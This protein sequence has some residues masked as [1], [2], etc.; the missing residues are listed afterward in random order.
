DIAR[1]GNSPALLIL[2]WLIT[3]F[4]TIT[5]ALAY[6]E[7]AAMMPK[8]GGQY[9]FLRE[10]LGPLWGFLYGWTLFLVIQTGTIAAVGVAFGTFLGYFFPAISAQNWIVH[11]PNTNIGLSTQN[12]V[13]ILVVLLLSAIN[14]YGIKTGALVQNVFTIAKV[15]ALFGL[16]LVG[17][18]VGRNPE[19]VAANFG[20]FWRNAS[21]GSQHLVAAGVT[22]GTLA[23]LAVAQTGSLFSADAWNNVTFT[24]AEV[25]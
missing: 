11:V 16:I 3:G 15:S 13:A 12:L 14:M 20:D 10:S 22:V 5:G 9:V 18:F 21:L 6:G 24:A 7:L 8:A 25:K 2:A 23:I 17:I 1:L 4:M 19:A